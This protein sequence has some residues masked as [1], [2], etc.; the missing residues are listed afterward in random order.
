MSERRR[1][2]NCRQPYFMSHGGR[3]QNYSKWYNFLV[4]GWNYFSQ[5][6]HK[7]TCVLVFSYQEFEAK[8]GMMQRSSDD[9]GGGQD[10]LNHPSNKHGAGCSQSLICMDGWP[11]LLHTHPPCPERQ[12]KTHCCPAA[13]P[14]NTRWSRQGKGSH[15]CTRKCSPHPG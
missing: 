3:Q 5:H 7:C 12:P 6:W 4:L 8:S 13:L 2:R 15:K 9:S 1:L 11:V 10:W 14:T